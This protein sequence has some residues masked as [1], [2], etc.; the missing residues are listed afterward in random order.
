[1]SAIDCYKHELLGFIICPS[2]YDFV[3]FS[4]TRKI[5]IYKLLQL[6]PEDENDFDGL[7]GDILVGGGSGEAP[8]FR[9]S[10]PKAF[11]FFAREDPEDVEFDTRDEL[12]KAFWGPNSAFIFCE[13]YLKLG[14]E[15]SYDIE[16]WLAENVCQVLIDSFD[17]FA[18]YREHCTN[19]KATLSFVPTIIEKN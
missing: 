19:V 16:S 6:I 12:Y 5:A 1:M 9:I 13:G 15:P 14:W 7:S 2:T 11:D 10:N 8:A 3:P 17:E 18:R 4:E